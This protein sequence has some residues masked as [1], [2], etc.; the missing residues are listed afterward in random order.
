MTPREDRD[1][2]LTQGTIDIRVPILSMCTDGC[3]HA[4]MHTVLYLY[5]NQS[6][7]NNY[8][9]IKGIILQILLGHLESHMDTNVILTPV[10]VL[11]IS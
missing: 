3:G 1:L 11:N 9:Q 8:R 5:A 10:T 6:C 2:H 4:N 7:H